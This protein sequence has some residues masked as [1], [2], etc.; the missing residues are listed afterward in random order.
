MIE[1]RQAPAEHYSWIAERAHLV[2][3]SGFRAI[4]ALDGERIVGM[5]G[6]DG[7]AA[8]EGRAP[9]SCSVHFAVDEPIALRRLIRPAFGIPFEELHLGVLFVQVRSDNERS[10]K[11]VQGLGFR[12]VCFLFDAYAVGVGVHVLEMRREECR[13][14]EG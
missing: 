5:V 14:L 6:Y 9:H 2:V 3:S 8:L 13:W 10:L 11:V 1:V 12:E 7:W 4:E